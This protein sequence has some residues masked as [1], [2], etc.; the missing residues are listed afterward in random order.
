VST[1]AVTVDPAFDDALARIAQLS[2]R[3]HAV[4][5][6]HVSR[7]TLLGGHA[8]RACGRPAPCPTSVATRGRA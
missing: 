7:R 1:N 3:L 4:A 2:A 5:D 6:L 8:C